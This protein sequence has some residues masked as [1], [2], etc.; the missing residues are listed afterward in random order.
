MLLEYHA[1]NSITK[2]VMINET[3]YKIPFAFRIGEDNQAPE[4]QAAI[5]GLERGIV[6]DL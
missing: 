2:G 3:G 4:W 5:I 1:G 6:L